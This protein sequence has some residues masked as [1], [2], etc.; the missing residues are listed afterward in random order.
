MINLHSIKQ[1]ANLLDICG[2]DTTLARV[3]STKGGE[4]AGPCP[5]CGGEDRFR[6]QPFAKP[7]SIWMCR[8]CTNARW[9]TVIGYIAKQHNLSTKRDIQRICRIAIEKNNLPHTH[10]VIKPSASKTA[11]APPNNIWQQSAKCVIEECKSTLWNPKFNSV[12]AYLHNRG[13]SDKTIKSFDLGFCS[14]GDPNIMGRKIAG[15]WIP[16]GIVIPCKVADEI[17]YIKVRLFPGIPYK[18]QKCHAV[19]KGKAVCEICGQ[20]NKYRGV[21]GNKP[22]AIFNADSLRGA[23]IALFCEGEFDAMIAEQEIG[24]VLPCVTLGGAENLPDLASWG[25]YLIPMQHFLAAYDTDKAGAKG[26]QKFSALSNRAHHVSIPERFKD[27]S[28]FY[29]DGNDLWEWIKP[30]LDRVVPMKSTSLLEIAREL[31][32]SI[33][34]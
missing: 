9:D 1:Q 14:T 4:Y 5:F 13:L 20:A 31:G 34:G 8:Q 22:L 18:C 16:R 10:N 26:I 7:Y 23:N 15:I 17:W 11:Y 6:V 28:E 2:Q 19:T 3:A 27:I 29:L 32:G 25:S 33:P 21:K 24:D 12:L 30:E